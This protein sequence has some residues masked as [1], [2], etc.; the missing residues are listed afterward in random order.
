MFLTNKPSAALVK[1]FIASQKDLQFSYSEVGATRGEL[2]P[3][4]NHDHHSI[5]LGK[6]RA[7]FQR[8]VAALRAWQQFDLGWVQIVPQNVSV[9][10]GAVVAVQARTFGIWSLSAARVVYVL[11]EV[12]AVS[13]F[14]FAYGTLPDHVERGEERFLIEWDQNTDAV[15]YDILAF[16]QPRHPLVRIGSPLA[17]SLQKRF[18]RESLM[19][20][21]AA[22][23]I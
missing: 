11:N 13:T 7:V 10:I 15:A 18:A 12:D 17:R 22:V 23:T 9:K 4:Y 19:R 21:R 3:G 20:M 8:A 6:G 16:S 14:G 5:V 1:R 2:P